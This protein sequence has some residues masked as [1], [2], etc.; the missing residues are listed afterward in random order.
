MLAETTDTTTLDDYGMPS[1]M[2][3]YVLVSRLILFIIL[4]ANLAVVYGVFTVMIR[5]VKHKCVVMT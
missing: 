4:Y 5:K 3:L 2:F 1:F